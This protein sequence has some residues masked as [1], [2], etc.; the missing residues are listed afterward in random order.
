[1]NLCLLAEKRTSCRML[2]SS[3]GATWLM[4]FGEVPR[5]G[6]GSVLVDVIVWHPEF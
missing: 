3:S 2:L 6:D 4:R 1:M 5:L